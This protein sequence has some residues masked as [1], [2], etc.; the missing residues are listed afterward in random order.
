MDVVSLNSGQNKEYL[1]IGQIFDRT[2]P[3]FRFSNVRLRHKDG[4]T[5]PMTDR[6][7]VRY[8]T[9]FTSCRLPW[10]VVSWGAIL[11]PKAFSLIAT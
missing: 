3:I 11:L 1:L 4:Q 5:C 10:P 7:K 6:Y 8:I 9:V 2:L